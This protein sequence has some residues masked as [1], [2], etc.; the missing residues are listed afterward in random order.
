[1]S[2][3]WPVKPECGCRLHWQVRWHLCDKCRA[4][5]AL[6]GRSS[7]HCAES[8][9]GFQQLGPPPQLLGRRQLSSL[10]MI[11][12]LARRHGM[13]YFECDE[14]RCWELHWGCFA[15]GGTSI[16]AGLFVALRGSKKHSDGGSSVTLEGGQIC[17]CMRCYCLVEW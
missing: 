6:C 7:S 17:Q 4:G 16:P 15:G 5:H 3:C 8:R 10:D 2:G 13:M 9:S 11:S 1:M 12:A 14:E